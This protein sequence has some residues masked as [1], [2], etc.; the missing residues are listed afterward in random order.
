M[1]DTTPLVTLW[2]SPPMGYLAAPNNGYHPHSVTVR[3]RAI[4]TMHGTATASSVLAVAAD[5]VLQSTE[6][7]TCQTN[8]MTDSARCLLA[9][10]GGGVLELLQDLRE[11]STCKFNKFIQ[12]CPTR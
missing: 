2:E 4:V 12:S 6:K 7:A 5:N 1:R 9:S 3:M 11:N 8:T 10:Q